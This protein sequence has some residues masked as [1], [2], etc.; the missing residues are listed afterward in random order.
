MTYRTYLLLAPRTLSD[1]PDFSPKGRMEPQA[2]RELLGADGMCL[3]VPSPQSEA[4][5]HEMEELSLQPTQNLPP[6]NERKNGEATNRLCQR[7]DRMMKWT[8]ELKECRQ[9]L[10]V[11]DAKPQ[12]CI[13]INTS[14]SRECQRFNV[15]KIGARESMS[16]MVAEVCRRAR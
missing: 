12:A 8:N 2:S 1:I 10:G 13:S 9:K 5:T 16:Y 14:L 7:I 6:L 11:G 15:G 3:L 4:V